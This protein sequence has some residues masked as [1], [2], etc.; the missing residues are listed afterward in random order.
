M[1]RGRKYHVADYFYFSL[2]ISAQGCSEVSPIGHFSNEDDKANEDIISV[3]KI[4][5]EQSYLF[6]DYHL[7]LVYEI[8][9]K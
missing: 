8:L 2:V 1:F 9:Y 6:C 7:H 5:F 4:T 3:S